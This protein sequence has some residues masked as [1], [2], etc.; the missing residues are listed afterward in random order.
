MN[1]VRPVI[2][3]VIVEDASLDTLLA[4]DPRRG[5]VGEKPNY[6]FVW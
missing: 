4:A 5:H 2:F 6:I 3:V 1:R